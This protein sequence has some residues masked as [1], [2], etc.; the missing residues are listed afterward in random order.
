MLIYDA[1]EMRWKELKIKRDPHC[2]V[3]G[4]KPSVT[5]LID[6]EAFCG[7]AKQ[8]P[9]VEEVLPE[10]GIVQLDVGSAAKMLEQSEPPMLVDVRTDMEWQIA[11][12]SERG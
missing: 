2:P 4:D 11:R 12:I 6:Y 7:G 9:E 10:D 3:C 8:E 5:E 1:L